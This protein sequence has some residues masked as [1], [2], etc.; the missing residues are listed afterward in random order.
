MIR[1]IRSWA[2]GLLIALYRLIG[3]STRVIDSPMDQIRAY[4]R[5]GHNLI[6]AIWHEFSVIG[7]YWYRHRHA[8]ALIEDS[9]KGDVLSD[10]LHH[11]G[12]Q[13]FRIGRDG[14]L[15]RPSRG[16]LSFIR[17]LRRGYDGTIA[18]DGPDGPAR[19][20]KPGILHIAAKSGNLILPAGAYFSH[21]LRFGWRWD[22]YQIPLPFSRL[23][24]V[25][26]EAIAVP[27]DIRGREQEFLSQLNAATDQA[28][29]EARR[30]GR[31]H[32][33]RRRCRSQKQPTSA[34]VGL[35]SRARAG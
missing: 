15:R 20:A 9:W 12:F 13:A 24:I 25:L 14:R 4:H 5:Q 35:S 30:I 1:G 17:F 6:F 32:P 29:A 28:T 18:M 26:G 34:A 31:R 23:H 21:A 3:A 16:M 8:S 27:E 10:V 19:Q 2:S 33:H 11:F 7:I 22:N